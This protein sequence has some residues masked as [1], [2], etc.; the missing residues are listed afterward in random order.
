MTQLL[1]VPMPEV[2]NTSIANLPEDS[3]AGLSWYVI[4]TKPA[5]EH[6]VE[7]NL[8]Q[9]ALEVYLPLLEVHQPFMGKIIQRIKPLFPSYLFARLD[10]PNHYYS[11]K[12]TR[13]VSKI[14]GIRDEPLPLAE[15]VIQAIKN[16]AGEDRVMKLREDYGEGDLVQITSGPLKDLVGIFQRKTSDEERVRV[17]LKL[18]GAEIPATLPVWQIKRVA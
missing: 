10:L 16:R 18:I 11:V 4:Q 3:T 5:D 1:N 7:A 15:Q 2:L 17:L 8:K 6:R 9:Q 13:G 12:W 14:L